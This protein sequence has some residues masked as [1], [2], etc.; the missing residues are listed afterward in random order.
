MST[1]DL[2]VRNLAAWS[3]QVAVLALAAAALSRVL[4]IERPAARLAFG[5]ALLA[6]VLLLPLVQPWHAAMSGVSWSLSPA[7]C[8]GRCGPARDAGRSPRVLGDPW[9]ASRRGRPAA[10]GR[11]VSPGS[12]RLRARPPSFP[13]SRL[14]ATRCAAMASRPA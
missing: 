12:R 1:V 5:Q 7:P 8:G 6:L 2:V 3:L 4:P 14:A 10:A 13:P 11:R 9:L